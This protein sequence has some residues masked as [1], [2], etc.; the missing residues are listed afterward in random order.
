M[1]LPEPSGP[2]YEVPPEMQGAVKA[3]GN[4]PT[5]QVAVDFIVNILCGRHRMS[6]VAGVPNSAETMVFFEGRRFVGEMLARMIDRPID[7]KPQ[8]PEPPARTMTEKAARRARLG[9]G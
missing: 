6:F 4:D 2:P 3:L 7:K 9:K 5:H 8:P 1:Q